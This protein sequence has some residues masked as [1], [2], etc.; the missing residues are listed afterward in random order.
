MKIPDVPVDALRKLSVSLNRVPGQRIQK[1]V[2]G[3]VRPFLVFETDVDTIAAKNRPF[4][5]VE[6]RDT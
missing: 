3:T 5:Q 4:V 2:L 1:P 6:A